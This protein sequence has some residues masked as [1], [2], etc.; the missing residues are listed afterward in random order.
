MST[1]RFKLSTNSTL[2]TCTPSACIKWIILVVLAEM[3]IGSDLALHLLQY[4]EMNVEL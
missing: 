4:I 1:P 2:G 3:T